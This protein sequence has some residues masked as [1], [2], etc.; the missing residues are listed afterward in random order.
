MLITFAGLIFSFLFLFKGVQKNISFLL[1]AS[2]MIFAAYYCENFL[3]WRVFPFTKTAF[4]LFL[5]FHF[6][7][8]NLFTFFAYGK[9]KHNAQTGRWRIP[10]IQLH[11]LELLGGTIGAVAGQNFFHHK[12]RKKAY[13]AT[14][15]ATIII[16]AGL[17]IFIL[18]YL[19]II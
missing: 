15:F 17:C 12:N 9:D 7:C 8:I 11:T 19:K 6:P 18:H 5:L 3:R 4:L 13:M 16:Q 10:E 2:A 14:F 1:Y